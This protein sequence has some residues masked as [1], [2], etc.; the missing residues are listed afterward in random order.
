MVRSVLCFWAVRE[1]GMPVT[2]LA[3]RLEMS[4]P[5][6]GYAVQRGEAIVRDHHY[7][8]TS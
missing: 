3:K 7:S 5:A 2:T 6:V 8:L 4:A 1:L